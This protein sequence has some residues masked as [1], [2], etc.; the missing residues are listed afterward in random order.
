ANSGLYMEP[1]FVEQV[2]TSEGEVLE[3]HSPQARKAMDA[4]AAYV[5]T[6]MLEG[7][8]DHGTAYELASLDVDLA[9][10][11]GTTN[12][13]TDA[14]FVGFTPKL[15]MLTWV[16]YDVKKTLGNNMTGAIAALPAWKALAQRGLDE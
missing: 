16:G 8:I 4:P 14:W 1:Y 10:K 3:T 11:T 9:G 6:H 15:T 13:Y 5:L 7:V 12:D 2:S